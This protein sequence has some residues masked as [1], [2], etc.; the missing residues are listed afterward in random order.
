MLSESADCVSL[1]P[2]GIALTEENMAS[3]SD[4][5]NE[6][7]KRKLFLEFSMKLRG[8]EEW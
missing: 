8:L 1:W 7:W 3:L 2:L 5:A 4:T 6:A